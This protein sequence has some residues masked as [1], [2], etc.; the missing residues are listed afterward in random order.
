MCMCVH[1]LTLER[2]EC[3]ACTELLCCSVAT[4]VSVAMVCVSVWEVATGLVNSYSKYEVD[5]SCCLA[6]VWHSQLKPAVFAIKRGY[7]ACDQAGK[8]VNLVSLCIMYGCI[9]D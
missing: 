3:E 5:V 9:L 8:H 6:Y 4:W 7:N 1:R 2:K